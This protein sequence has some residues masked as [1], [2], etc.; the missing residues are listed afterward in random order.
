[1]T[2]RPSQPGRGDGRILRGA[3]VLVVALALAGCSDDSPPES[4]P[5]PS[6]SV[7]AEVAPAPPRATPPPRPEVGA[8]YRLTYAE[9]LAPTTEAAAVRCARPHTATTYHVGRLD[10]VVEGHLLAVDARRVRAQAADACPRRLQPFLGGTAEQLR[11]TVLRPVW[12]SPSLEQSD[13][14]Q[15]WFRCDV[16]SLAGDERLGRLDPPPRRVLTTAV[17]R[18]AYGMCGTAEP[19]TPAFERVVCSAPHTWRAVASYELSGRRYPGR[20]ELRRLADDR[21]RAVGQER[22]EDPLT[23]RWGFDYPSREQWRAGVRF[24]LCWIPD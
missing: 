19:G 16:I 2:P 20:A 22:A 15:D 5:S 8:C 11:L 10:T 24:G 1:M 7:T 18:T 6:S 13:E 3:V 4:D 9:A 14:G 17:G 23:Y 21:C 12:F